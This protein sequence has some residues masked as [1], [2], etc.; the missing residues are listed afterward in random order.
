MKHRSAD[1]FA[2]MALTL[3]AVV[4][5]LVTPSNSVAERIWTLPLVLLL[6]GYAMICALFTKRTLTVLELFIFSMGLSLS[7]VI[8]GGLLLNLT[9]FGLRIASWAVLLGGTTVG[10]SALALIR[11]RGQSPSGLPGFGRIGFTFR[12]WLFLGLAVM[13]V[14]GALVVSVIGAQRQPFPGFT[15]FWILPASAAKAGNVVHLGVKNMES[16]SMEYRLVV[17]MNG[18]P[19]KV[20]SAINLNQNDTWQATLVLPQIARGSDAK[21]EA[22]LYLQDAPAQIYRDVVLWLGT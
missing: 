6:P 12:Q 19:V 1:L 13:I 22:M 8:V 10:A 11:R 2:V 14:G 15:Q 3:I 5:A 16:T 21:V 18:E 4:L 9:S 7:I 20:W 17:N